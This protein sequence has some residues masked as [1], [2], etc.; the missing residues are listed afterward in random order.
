MT[1]GYFTD[2]NVSQTVM[3]SFSR[4]GIPVKHI[5]DFDNTKPGVFYG[6][7]RGPGIAMRILKDRGIDFWYVDNGYFDAVYMN[8]GKRKEM[9]GTYRVVKNDLITP[10]PDWFPVHKKETHRP[11]SVL[12][13]P[14]SPYTAFMHDTTP[15]DW[16]ITWGQKIHDLGHSRKTRDKDEKTPLEDELRECDAVFA[17]NSMGVVKAIEMG[18][19]VYTTNGIIRNSHMLGEEIQYFNINDIKN[20]Y[21]PKQYTLA[22]IADLGVKCLQ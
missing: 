3:K 4:R 16:R 8:E 7:L 14:P 15:E 1:I 13:M 19:A 11:L 2:N 17:F 21:E 18:K 20:F 5:R 10:T 22:E 12:L 9:N 6:I